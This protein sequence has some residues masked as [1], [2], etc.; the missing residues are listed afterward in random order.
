MKANKE[1]IPFIMP[2]HAKRIICALCSIV[3]YMGK[4][5]ALLLFFCLLLSMPFQRAY[6]VPSIGFETWT[7]YYQEKVF[8]QNFTA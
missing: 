1:P 4:L 6:I 5:K 7:T 8:A 3:K 2:C